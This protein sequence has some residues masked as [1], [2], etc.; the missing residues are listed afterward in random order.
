MVDGVA[1]SSAVSVIS[2]IS[3]VRVEAGLA[4]RRP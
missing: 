2:R 4:E 1:L 3:R